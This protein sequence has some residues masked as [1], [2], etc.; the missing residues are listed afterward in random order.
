MGFKKLS[1]VKFGAGE[2]FP[3]FIY[4]KKGRTDFKWIMHVTCKEIHII[5]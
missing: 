3:A 1:I 5:P 2:L 4:F